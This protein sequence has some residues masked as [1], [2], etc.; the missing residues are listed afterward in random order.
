MDNYLLCK[1]AELSRQLIARP[2]GALFLRSVGAQAQCGVPSGVQSGATKRMDSPCFPVK[3][4]SKKNSLTAMDGLPKGISLSSFTRF[5]KLELFSQFTNGFTG[6][7]LHFFVTAFGQYAI[8]FQ[9]IFFI[10]FLLID[11]SDI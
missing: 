7:F 6:Q 1:A 9:R 11:K 5:A 10:F 4:V 8:V 3:S 2:A